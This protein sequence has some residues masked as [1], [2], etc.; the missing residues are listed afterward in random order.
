MSTSEPVRIPALTTR[1][2]WRWIIAT[3]VG[4]VGLLVWS[5]VTGPETWSARLGMAAFA[6]ILAFFALLIVSTR[7]WLEPA[8]GAVAIERLWSWRRRLQLSRAT[9]VRLVGNG[10]GVVSVQIR[11][12]GHLGPRAIPVLSRTDYGDAAMPAEILSTLAEMLARWAPADVV[13]D[14]TERLRAQAVFLAGG[15]PIG[16]SPLAARASAG[17]GRGIGA[18]GAAGGASS[19]P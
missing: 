10:G 8:T 19:L 16:D 18:A 6:A 11:A 9:R 15:G 17:P 4:L 7:L 12:A 3:G 14:V 2:A 13:G 1:S 5:F